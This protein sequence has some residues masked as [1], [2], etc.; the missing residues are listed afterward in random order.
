[1]VSIKF[2]VS[3]FFR[4]HRA[5]SFVKSVKAFY[6]QD[7]FV[8]ASSLAI[9]TIFGFVPLVAVILKTQSIFL[10]EKMNYDIIVT[11]IRFFFPSSTINFE[12]YA[13]SYVVN[14]ELIPVF[15]IIW[16]LFGSFIFYWSIEST[17]NS[18]HLSTKERRGSVK[19]RHFLETITLS[20]I[21]IGLVTYFSV[22]YVKPKLDV[23]GM[24]AQFSWLY[25]ILFPFLI[26]NTV[27]FITFRRLP[28]EPLKLSTT[29]QG[30]ILA[31]FLYIVSKYVFNLFTINFSNFPMI[32]EGLALAV[33]WVLWVE[34]AWLIVLYAFTW[35]AVQQPEEGYRLTYP[36]NAALYLFKI[37]LDEK[38]QCLD[39]TETRF[40]MNIAK[41]DY[42]FLM[43]T[44][45][46]N[47]YV[48]VTEN[49]EIILKQ[50]LSNIFVGD[51]LQLFRPKVLALRV[52]EKDAL[53][54]H[55]RKSI[56]SNLPLEQSF[57]NISIIQLFGEND[58]DKKQEEELSAKIKVL[59]SKK[60]KT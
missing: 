34:V 42:S 7:V 53:T 41:L 35:I 1:M 24:F 51:V 48:V 19:I 4:T 28:A 6:K 21:I 52:N 29:I 13:L 55:L 23:I 17:F 36:A 33:L 46:S 45:E 58:F 40:K 10:S 16:A 20:A 57:Q 49:N 27:I 18:I 8:K 37:F 9:T 2:K 38:T 43:D 3:E 11:L 50:T 14:T 56:K 25:D 5:N 26:G 44:L 22:N 60:S 59:P 12:K 32:Y 30:T 31:S 39:F 47:N 15:G 54:K